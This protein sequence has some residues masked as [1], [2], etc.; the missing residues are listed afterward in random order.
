MSADPKYALAEFVTRA[1]KD[2]TIVV[3]RHLRRPYVGASDVLRA[4]ILYLLSGGSGVVNSGGESTRLFDLAKLVVEVLS[5]KSGV[6]L[7]DQGFYPQLDYISPKSE[8]PKEFWDKELDLRNQ[9]LNTSN[10]A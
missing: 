6:S 2:E 1:M 4:S 7:I 5:S 3:E 9:I 10:R 8:I